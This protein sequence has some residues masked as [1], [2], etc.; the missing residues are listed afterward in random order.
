MLGITV[1]VAAGDGG[2]DDGVGDGAAHVD[3]PASSPHALACGGTR[4]Q[5]AGGQIVAESVWN[6]GPGQGAG[7]G[8]VSRFFARPTW[9]NGLNSTLSNGTSTPL[10]MRGVPDV[11]GNADPDTGYQVRIDGQ[12]SVIGGTSAVAPLWAALIARINAA[13]GRPAGLIHPKI[14][15]APDALRDI[16]TGNNGDFAATKGWDACTGLGSPSGTRLAQLL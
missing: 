3:F 16:I 6:D 2:S 7:G 1:C 9:Q 5:A 15:G 12:A 13:N 4:L 8:G 10:S 11:A 14:Y